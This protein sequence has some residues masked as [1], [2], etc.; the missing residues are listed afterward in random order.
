MVA[1]LDPW[2]RLSVIPRLFQWVRHS[3]LVRLML[4]SME[5][6]VLLLVGLDRDKL[7]EFGYFDECDRSF[8]CGRSG[9]NVNSIVCRLC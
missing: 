3:V 1:C 6:D 7:V 2:L 5:R 4:V 9:D 8:E